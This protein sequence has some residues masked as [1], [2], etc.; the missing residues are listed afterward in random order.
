[1]LISVKNTCN[2]HMV[3]FNKITVMHIST[4]LIIINIIYIKNET[5]M[6]KR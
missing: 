4:A 1:M 2:K 3:I 6:Y 5:R